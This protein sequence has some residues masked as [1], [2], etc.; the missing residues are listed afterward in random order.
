MRGHS[1]KIMDEMGRKEDDIIVKKHRPSAF[2]GTLLDQILRANGIK[3]V[4][5]TGVVSEGCVQATAMDALWR[6][7]YTVV[8]KDCIATA[9]AER[10][11][12]A[13]TFMSERLEVHDSQEIISEWA[14]VKLPA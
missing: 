8:A 4:I 1:P 7:F 5:V 14:K 9:D 3:S 6:D 11:A 2:F 12:R 13:V 10:Q